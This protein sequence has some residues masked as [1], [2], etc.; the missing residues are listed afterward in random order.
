MNHEVASKLVHLY[1]IHK[2]TLDGACQQRGDQGRSMRQSIWNSIAASI[3]GEFGKEYTIRQ[4]KKKLQNM[5]ASIRR[6]IGDESGAIEMTAA[7]RMR[8]TD[9]ENQLLDLVGPNDVRFTNTSYQEDLNDEPSHPSETIEHISANMFLEQML[10]QH[11]SNGAD[12]VNLPVESPPS[13]SSSTRKR[14][15][16]G[17]D[18]VEDFQDTKPVP[19]QP[20]P[21]IDTPTETTPFNFSNISNISNMFPVNI[22]LK[23]DEGRRQGRRKTHP[24]WNFFRSEAPPGIGAICL[25]CNTKIAHGV[26]TSLCRHVLS[27]HPEYRSQVTSGAYNGNRPPSHESIEDNQMEQD[28]PIV[29][30]LT[31]LRP[32]SNRQDVHNLVAKV[33]MR[34]S[35]VNILEDEAFQDILKR[36]PNYTPPTATSLVSNLSCELDK[37]HTYLSERIYDSS[38]IVPCAN[39]IRRDDTHVI[40]ILSSHMVNLEGMQVDRFVVDAIKC[41]KSALNTAIIAEMFMEFQTKF[42]GITDKI[43]NYFVCSETNMVPF[44]VK[45]RGGRKTSVDQGEATHTLTDV[46]QDAMIECAAPQFWSFFD[47]FYNYEPMKQVL[48]KLDSLAEGVK[49]SNAEHDTS[50]IFSDCPLPGNNDWSSK[51]AFYEFLHQIYTSPENKFQANPRLPK[52][53]SHQKNLLE[54]GLGYLKFVRSFLDQMRTPGYPTISMIVPSVLALQQRLTVNPEP[55]NQ[56]FWELINEAFKAHFSVYLQALTPSCPEN[57][58]FYLLSSFLDRRSSFYLTLEYKE[59]AAEWLHQEFEQ[60]SVEQNGAMHEEDEADKNDPFSELEKVAM[61]AKKPVVK[62]LCEEVRTYMDQ[63]STIKVR[64]NFSSIGFWKDHSTDLPR[65]TCKALQMLAIPTG[66]EFAEAEALLGRMSDD[67]DVIPIRTVAMKLLNQQYC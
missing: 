54:F 11:H 27:K 61:G 18:L 43:N 38:S 8:L 60:T 36:I 9:G 39:V 13:S 29:N 58:R 50:D 59:R 40:V 37:F 53:T 46:S 35:N 7:K 5:Y 21:D 56:E 6:K 47:C 24:V 10:Q 49:R 20:V 45:L 33:L 3:N 30:G 55:Q 42:P 23:M 32:H 62:G 64:K 52:L 28:Q 65:L 34:D 57:D 17:E 14:S 66:I 16:D 67:A 51:L 2:A 22:P 41:N 19:F 1:G 48:D 12:L 31:V 25:I 4:M 26:S 44:V 15:N 63:F